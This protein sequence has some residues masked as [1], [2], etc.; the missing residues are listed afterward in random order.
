[1]TRTALLLIIFLFST[2]V[3]AF[4][5]WEQDD[6]SLELRGMLRGFGSVYYYPAI[7]SIYQN[8]EEKVLTGVAR[9][10]GK[11]Q[12]NNTTSYEF[13]LYEAYVPGKTSAK[14]LAAVD[15]ERSAILEWSQSA[16]EYAHLAIDRLNVRWQFDR[17]DLIV[18]R[19]AVNLATTFY[20]APNDFF[21]P[22]SA[23][24][25]YRVYKPGVDAIRAEYRLA[26]L[27][28]LTLLTVM[29]YQSD[30]SSVNGWSSTLDANRHS[31]LARYSTVW[32]DWEWS[33]L[34]GK[35]QL[36]Q[37]VGGSLQGS[38]GGGVGL[39]SEFHQARQNNANPETWNEFTIG[40]EH[41]FESS[42]DVRVE[43]FFHG[44]GAASVA[45]YPTLVQL[46]SMRGSSYLAS[47]YIALG[48][49]YEFGPLFVGSAALLKNMIDNS[50]S[51]AL[52]GNY[53]LSDEADLALT[54]AYANGDVPV[55]TS[56]RQEFGLAA[57]AISAEVRM[58]F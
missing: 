22:F 6:A 40:L 43:Y 27:T 44:Q 34:M 26:N 14:Q 54:L 41:R 13:N 32:R 30:S 4:Y 45:E 7:P 12:F 55:G 15:V 9:L 1:M 8:S 37:V 10:I 17:L 46:A 42:L 36:K 47:Q 48:I 38:L 11:G 25:F 35:V 19:Q 56:I 28:Q 31:Y 21:A 29:G 39:R 3:N 58:H 24:T 16:T 2:T 33:A 57:K 51:V 53:S 23:Q 5:T 52:N 20:F 50:T 18:G 49:G